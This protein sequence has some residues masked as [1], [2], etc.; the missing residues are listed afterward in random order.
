MNI[1]ELIKV[2]KSEL[3]E[4]AIDIG[5]ALELLLD[6]LKITRIDIGTKLQQANY[7]KDFT[8]LGQLVAVSQEIAAFE[9]KIQD[10]R[11]LFELDL[12]QYNIETEAEKEKSIPE[13]DKYRVDTNIEFTL[14]EDFTHKR[15]FAFKIEGQKVTVNTWQE[16]LIKTVEILFKKDRAKMESFATDEEMNGRKMK[17]FSLQNK[18]N[19]RKP[20]KISD[21]EFYVETNR[22]ANSIR[23]SIIKMLQRYG[24]KITDFKIYLRAD[25]SDLHN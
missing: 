13:Y 11:N 20:V 10:F 8:L 19:M 25:Y 7:C 12:I 6:T 14:Y 9:S 18:A 16:M 24:L 3:P 23:N 22:S 5:E 17:Y 4:K 2:L 15:P 21:V 1:N